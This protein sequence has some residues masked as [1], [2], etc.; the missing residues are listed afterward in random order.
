MR[1]PNS[2]MTDDEFEFGLEQAMKGVIVSDLGAGDD[3]AAA[4][5][6][7][8]EAAPN[9]PPELIQQARDAYAAQQLDPLFS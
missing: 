5:F 8:I 2:P 9:V 3:L 6:A 1:L 7:I 4:F